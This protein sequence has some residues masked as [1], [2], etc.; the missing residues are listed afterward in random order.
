[1]KRINKAVHLAAALIIIC[2]L[3]VVA[4][5][6]GEG[7][8]YLTDRYLAAGADYRKA[9][10][11]VR[12]CADPSSFPPT[13]FENEESDRQEIITDSNDVN[14]TTVI[15]WFSPKAYAADHGIDE[16]YL[17]RNGECSMKVED[18]E[19]AVSEITKIAD[20]YGGMISDSQSSKSDDGEH[21]GWLVVRVPSGKFLRAWQEILCVGY[22]DEQKITLTFTGGY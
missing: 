18:Y 13:V 15:A 12:G 5:G 7:G 17:V 2:S 14:E 19:A 8:G 11:S 22:V 1:M 20:S 21:V 9:S 10:N 3:S 6:G 4:C 16:K